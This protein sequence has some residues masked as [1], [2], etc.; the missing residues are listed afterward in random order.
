MKK[1]FSQGS[2]KECASE[3]IYGFEWRV[4]NAAVPYIRALY[5]MEKRLEDVIQEKAPP[6]IWLVTHPSV[7][8]LGTK[9]SDAERKNVREIGKRCRVPTIDVG[10]GGQTTYHGPGQR[11]VYVVSPLQLF[12]NSLHSFL[13]FLGNLCVKVCDRLGVEAFYDAKRIG[14]W[15]QDK[16]LGKKIVSFGLRVRKK[17]IYHGCCLNVAP[18]LR[19]FNLIR[20]CGLSGLEMTSLALLG[21]T[22]EMDAVDC[23]LRLAF[24]EIVGQASNRSHWHTGG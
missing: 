15:A 17:H 4:E 16:G 7:Y 21:G 10:R 1:G 5:M 13:S 12:Q 9:T 6:L 23:A 14:V 20:P 18:N 11:M 24:L 2:L 22:T 8:T 19:Y 3:N